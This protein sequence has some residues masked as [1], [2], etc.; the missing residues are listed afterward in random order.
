MAYILDQQRSKDCTGAFQR[1]RDYLD[2]LRGTFPQS[3][4]NLATSDWYFN[5]TDPRCPHDARLDFVSVSEPPMHARSDS[6]SASIRIR[7]S[8]ALDGGSA[9]FFYPKVVRYTF[10]GNL[11]TNGHADWRY[12][13]FTVSESGLLLHEIEW[14]G[15]QDTCRWL[16]EATDVHYTT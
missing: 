7:I 13:E 5:F 9:E 3:A 14:C 2:G 16:I 6:S 11:A 10:Q 8:L 12:D 4:L 1:Y 15:P